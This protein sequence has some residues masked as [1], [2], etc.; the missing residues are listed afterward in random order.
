MGRRVE[1]EDRPAGR[2]LAVQ[3]GAKAPIGLLTGEIGSGKTTVCRRLVAAARKRGLP[4]GGILS[5]PLN[6]DLG[7]RIGLL[8]VDLSSGE[9][10]LLASL[11]RS[12]GGPRRGLYS[13]DPATFA[14]AMQATLAALSADP[15]LIIVDEIGPIE[16]Q[17]G[18]GFAPLLEPLLAADCP[19]LLVVRRACRPALAALLTDGH[20]AFEVHP[21][22]RQDLPRR[23]LA[24]LCCDA[25]QRRP[26][27]TT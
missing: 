25:G 26:A 4:V 19:L 5:R 23:I 2:A 21:G 24:A 12:L 17:Q 8:A 14:W 16:L 1:P 15:A 3:A 7:Q 6:D 27:A 22:S 20:L 13:F 10:R 18:A 9:E 11:Q